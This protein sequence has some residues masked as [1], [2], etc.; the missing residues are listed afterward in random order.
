MLPGLIDSNQDLRAELVPPP[1]FK[2]TYYLG[3]AGGGSQILPT[4]LMRTSPPEPGEGPSIFPSFSG[5]RCCYL[6]AK[7]CPTFYDPM[8]CSMPGFPV[9][10]YLPE[11]DQTHVHWV[12][13]VILPS[14]PLS[15]TSPP[16]FNLSQYWGLFQWGWVYFLWS[17][18]PCT[19]LF[20]LQMLETS[21]CVG[22]ITTFL[23][24]K[25]R[26]LTLWR[27]LLLFRYTNTHVTWSI[28]S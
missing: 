23:S 6:V 12:G 9:L 18:A 5:S 20:T 16:A 13:D 24:C 25:Y 26:T 8:D 27:L 22:R 10:H 2:R 19:V 4:S 14:H 15:P 11:F 21:L 3:Q 28:W 17:S 1:A 7:S